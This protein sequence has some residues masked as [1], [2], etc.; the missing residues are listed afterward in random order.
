[1]AAKSQGRPIKLAPAI[2]IN[3][4]AAIAISFSVNSSVGRELRDK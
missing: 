3:V 1:M 2:S 4:L